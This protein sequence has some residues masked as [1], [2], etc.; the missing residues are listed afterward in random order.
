MLGGGFLLRPEMVNAFLVLHIVGGSI[1]VVAGYAA[2]VARKGGALHR[3]VGLAFVYSMIAMGIGAA[4]VGLAREK[5]TW[6]GGLIV[7]YY[8]ITATRTMQ[9]RAQPTLLV[10]GGLLVMAVVMCLL[11]LWGRNFPFAVLL[12]A[13]AAGDA[14]I[15]RSGPLSGRP[16]L[17]RHLWRMCFATF[18]AT[19][20]F[21][22]G[23]AQVIPGPLRIWPALFVLALG[24]L[25]FLLYWLWRVR[26]PGYVLPR[27]RAAVT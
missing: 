7:I 3:R 8:V 1:A 19:G 10:D 18:F 21:F 2:L 26:R 16:R 20:S 22:L 12:L 23:Q 17:A 13:A 27:M 9:R 4:V 14:R 11:C 6:L 24:P 25:A 15:L 5:T